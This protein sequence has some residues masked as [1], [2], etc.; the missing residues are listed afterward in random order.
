MSFALLQNTDSITAPLPA[1]RVN[2]ST[3]IWSRSLHDGRRAP[4]LRS[5][6]R[7][8]DKPAVLPGRPA[9]V[10]AIG[11][12]GDTDDTTGNRL[13]LRT[14]AAFLPALGPVLWLQCAAS[15]KPEPQRSLGR[16][17][18]LLFAHADLAVLDR[19]D[20]VRA[21][22]EVTSRGPREWLAFHDA[23]DGVLAKLFLLPDTDCFGWDH[24]LEG[25]AV[26]VPTDSTQGWHSHQAFRRVAFARL[27]S[28]WQASVRAFRFQH[29]LFASLLTVGQPCRVSRLGQELARRIADDE[30]AVLAAD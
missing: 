22:F 26:W 12:G 21:H 18:E 23:N 3:A 28:G 14:I 11:T 7:A 9:A 20:C 30:C 8:F 19:C 24:M 4:F 15:D 16:N 6:Q 1:E 27:H 29:E 2:A 5:R 17:G 25:C 10:N 13:D